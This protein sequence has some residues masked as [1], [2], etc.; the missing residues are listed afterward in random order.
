MTSAGVAIR[1]DRPAPGRSLPPATSRDGTMTWGTAVRLAAAG[2]SA[3]GTRIALTAAGAAAGT[4]ALL[5]AATVTATGR[6]DGPYTSEL[7]NQT[8]LHPGIVAALVLLCVPVLAFVGQCARIGAPARD[9]RLAALRLQGATPADVVRVAAGETA[10]SAGV[11]AALGTGLFFLL[12]ALL[13]GPVVATYTLERPVT[14]DNGSTGSVVD[15]ITGPALRLPTDVLPPWP[16]LVLV[17]V[18]LPL[19]TAAFSA[20]ALR[21]VTLSPFGVVRRE[22][23]APARALPGLL[24]VLGTAGLAGFAALRRLLHVGQE[25]FSV[26]GAVALLLF[27]LTGLGLLLGTSALSAGIGRVLA[28]RSG[29]PSLLLAGRR[30]LAAPGQGGRAHAAVLLVVLLWAFAQGVRV[31]LLAEVDQ[32]RSFYTGALALVD[33]AFGVGAAVAAASL[34]IGTVESILTRRRVLAG[35]VAVG[36]PRAV[37][38]R[39][40]LAETLAPLAPAVVLAATAG[41]LAARGVLGTTADLPGTSATGRLPVPWLALGTLAGGTLLAVLAVTLL[42]LPLLHRSTHPAELRAG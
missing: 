37:L 40:V 20:L 11:G 32:D 34:V 33:L 18:A 14:Y 29:R 7:L 25:S 24:F 31:W 38:F 19:L 8:G 13:G 5:A 42:T 21:T 35:L 23:S 26:P 2:G 17:V 41:I 39:A 4:L 27:L 16:A 15:T 6:G 10:L 9:R 36:T 1:Q 3:D 28:T 22:Q 30:L 12:R